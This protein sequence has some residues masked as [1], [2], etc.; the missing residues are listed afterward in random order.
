MTIAPA[1]FGDIAGDLLVGNFGDGKINVF[2]QHT[3]TFVGQLT[4]PNGD[5]ISIDGLWTITPGNGG[6]AGNPNNLYFT[7]GINGKQDGL[8][9]SLKPIS[10]MQSA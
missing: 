4:G 9:G 7:A 10:N 8:F 2:N 5:T 3:D 1:S 6:S